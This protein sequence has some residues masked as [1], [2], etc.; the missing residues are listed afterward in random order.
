MDGSAT[1]GVQPLPA[2]VLPAETAAEFADGIEIALEVGERKI[3]RRI[4]QT[5]FAGFAGCANREHARLDR[6]ATV[7]TVVATD[8][9]QAGVALAMIEVPFEG[10]G[11][12]HNAGRTQHTGFFRERIRKTS[13]RNIFWAEHRVAFFGNMRNR[14]NLAVAK[15]D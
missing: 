14:K 1:R 7:Q 2:A 8:F 12:G 9:E 3:A 11:H 15:T 13:W 10:C 4:V 5:F 6:F